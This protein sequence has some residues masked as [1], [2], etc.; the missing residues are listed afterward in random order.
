[1]PS[2]S[3]YNSCFKTQHT[4][5]TTTTSSQAAQAT[6]LG[7]ITPDKQY[8][9][10]DVYTLLTQDG[11][12]DA[13]FYD[14]SFPP[15][16]ASLSTIDSATADTSARR[17][18][19]WRRPTAYLAKNVPSNVIYDEKSI[20]PRDI[21]Q[22][23]LSD[24]Y[25]TTALSIIA[26]KPSLVTRLFSA[27]GNTPEANNKG[28]YAVQL[29]ISGIWT[30]ILLDSFFPCLP[31]GTPVYSRCSGN[32]LWALLLEKAYAKVHGSYKAIKVGW[33][34]DALANLTG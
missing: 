26:E 8:T 6:A 24:F 19:V 13:Q 34:I 18:I 30:T 25:F 5:Y 29:C 4:L 3:T 9:L 17:T 33:S 1:M 32:K 23:Y 12:N 14:L 15:V 10:A 11:P 2:P 21:K 28:L 27:A 31:G 7:T 20:S 16:F 22:G